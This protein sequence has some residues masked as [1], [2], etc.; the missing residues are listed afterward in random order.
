MHLLFISLLHGALFLVSAEEITES[1]NYQSTIIPK[2]R[3]RKT[4]FS[5]YSN[6]IVASCLSLTESQQISNIKQQSRCF[7]RCIYKRL[8]ACMHRK[9]RGHT[10]QI[11]NEFR[12]C[13]SLGI[14]SLRQSMSMHIRGVHAHYLMLFVSIFN[15]PWIKGCYKHG[16]LITVS[17]NYQYF[18]GQ[19][20]PW[21]SF[22]QSDHLDITFYRSYFSQFVVN[23]YY[24]S[25]P[26]I[27]NTIRQNIKYFSIK[28]DL[29]YD[30]LPIKISFRSDWQTIK[31]IIIINTFI[32]S[33]IKANELCFLHNYGRTPDW[34]EVFDGP[35]RKS[36]LLFTAKSSHMCCNT[37]KFNSSGA[38]LIIYWLQR[39][40][41]LFFRF[42]ITLI[43]IIN[44]KLLTPDN[45]MFKS[46]FLSG[47]RNVFDA[48][49]VRDV[50]LD[51]NSLG[52]KHQV[53]TIAR[54]KFDGP[55][56]II[57][58]GI[59][60]CQYGGLFVLTLHLRDKTKAIRE[61]CGNEHI[62]SFVDLEGDSVIFMLWY[63]EYSSG[64]VHGFTVRNPCHI[65]TYSQG[66]DSPVNIMHSFSNKIECF[67]FIVLNYNGHLNVVLNDTFVE[68]SM[69][70]LFVQIKHSIAFHRVKAVNE[71]SCSSRKT[72]VCSDT[73]N[74]LTY[75]MYSTKTGLEMFDCSDF[76]LTKCILRSLPCYGT[77]YASLINIYR[78]VCSK[79][80]GFTSKFEEV[81]LRPNTQCVV[82]YSIT[83]APIL[84]LR[85]I[86]GLFYAT[87][88]YSYGLSP[89]CI[90]YPLPTIDI[91]EKS[92]LNSYRYR[93][94]V[95][96][97]DSRHKL[98]LSQ[99]IL[100]LLFSSG[101][102]H[103]Y[104][105]NCRFI[106]EFNVSPM[107]DSKRNGTLHNIAHTNGLTFHRKRYLAYFVLIKYNLYRVI[108]FTI[109]SKI[110]QPLPPKSQPPQLSPPHN[111]TTTKW[112]G[113]VSPPRDP[114]GNFFF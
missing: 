95:T 90:V 110:P 36:F 3:I 16:V 4:D 53:L 88:I 111:Q 97:M 44:Q 8:N 7:I 2:N 32:H 13:G 29:I 83:K 10:N 59:Y 50:S 62:P 40:S 42:N 60:N 47:P 73:E 35:G 18:C 80:L 1:H 104:Q 109:T 76:R 107:F 20:L 93:Y 55:S 39:E 103:E 45:A 38:M 96:G 87:D 43:S 81:L 19:R 48:Y 85:P 24:F 112:G 113:R 72:V 58:D 101:L 77:K 94:D 108:K 61:W 56:I 12:V 86:T 91:L 31:H 70:S 69:G 89:E 41:E 68:R 30:N 99:A 23:L 11:A 75:C 92:T 114:S 17:L 84:H 52:S 64:Q 98:R 100:T 6:Y 33:K 34:L 22:Y 54:Y 9:Q 71:A 14:N 66:M 51:I 78:G 15:T 26:V 5:L 28:T 21:T 102:I 46:Q 27:K 25:H 49:L 65:Q 74:R 63:S 57:S 106:I 105:E 67:T 82:S 37:C 79:T